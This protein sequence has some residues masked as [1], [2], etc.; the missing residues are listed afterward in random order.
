VRIVQAKVNRTRVQLTVAATAVELGQDQRES[1]QV[2]KVDEEV[3]FD[4][5]QPS[6]GVEVKVR[7]GGGKV[8]AEEGKVFFK[9]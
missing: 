3:G 9:K 6:G 5:K 1:E 4:K 7:A 8:P 2:R